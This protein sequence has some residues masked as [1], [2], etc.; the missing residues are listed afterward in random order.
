MD[1][2]IKILLCSLSLEEKGGVNNYVRI[3][4]DKLPKDKFIVEH[5]IQGNNS[6]FLKMFYP[7]IIFIQLSKFKEELKKYN[8]D[9]VH[10]NPSLRWT[11]IIRDY[12]FM[13]C[14]K[15]NGFRVVFFVRGWR[16]S[17]SKHFS[18]NNLISK[19]FYKIFIKPDLILVLANSFKND[20]ISLGINSGKIRV[21]TTMVEYEKFKPKKKIFNRPFIILFCAARIEQSKGIFQLLEAF[22]LVLEKHPDTNLIYLGQGNKLRKLRRKIFQMKLDKSVKCVG[23]KS[24]KEKIDYFHNSHILVLPSFT[25]GF[26]NIFCEALA[27]GLPFIGTHV[28]GLIDA[29]E[30]GKQGL[31]IKSMPPTP[32]EIFEKINMLLDNPDLIKRISDNNVKEAKEKYDVKVVLTKLEEIYKEL[33]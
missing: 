7:L 6:K 28:G 16:T 20:L 17:L 4:L 30:D 33:I 2:K 29:F 14:A 22:P 26:P 32:E 31:V 10:I 23:Y 5:F 11:S 27:A 1:D 8:P 21:T 15:K 19:F 13:K 24:G 25:E 12:L 3:L 18:N 9:I